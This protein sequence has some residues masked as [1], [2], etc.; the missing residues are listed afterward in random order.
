MARTRYEPSRVAFVYKYDSSGKQLW[1][2][3]LVVEG[4]SDVTVDAIT[5]DKR[6]YIYAAGAVAS[7]IEGGYVKSSMAMS[8]SHGR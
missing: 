1:K 8:E 2:H 7:G 6:G 4:S 3:N 5:V